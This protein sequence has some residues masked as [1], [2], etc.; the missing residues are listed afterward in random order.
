MQGAVI[1]P[2]DES[3]AAHYGRSA[4]AAEILQRN[5]P[6]D[7]GSGLLLGTVEDSTRLARR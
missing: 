6:R 5:R 7:A 3:N 1:R 4:T 2:D